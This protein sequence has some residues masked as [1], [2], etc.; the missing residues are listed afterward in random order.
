MNEDKFEQTPRNQVRRVAKRG[1]YDKETIY[2]IL[3]KAFLCHI[4]F[5]LD[6]QPFIIPTLYARVDDA[7]YI[8]GSHISRML[9]HL[10]TGE[11]IC[12]AVTHVD[13]IV[14]ARSAFHH[15]MNYRS[16]VIFGTGKLVESDEEKLIALKAI[17][18][19]ILQERWEDCREPNQKELNVTSVIKIEIE[20]ASAKIRE[21]MPID[22]DSDYNSSFWAGILP[23]NQTFG[24]PIDDDKLAD[25]IE[26]PNYLKRR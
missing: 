21:G 8:H 18:D 4:S 10:E 6:G 11:K 15:S 25:G 23:I 1:K 5:V 26:L 3:D 13:G 19:N 22:D 2:D 14:L 9:K 12:L 17:S 7:I 20:T 16:A 24:E